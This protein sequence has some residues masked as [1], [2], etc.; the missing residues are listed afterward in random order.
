MVVF[1]FEKENKEGEPEG[2][3]PDWLKAP[4]LW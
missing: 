1:H 4:A 3:P 2:S